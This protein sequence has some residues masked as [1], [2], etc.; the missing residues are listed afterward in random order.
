ML[1]KLGVNHLKN[2]GIDKSNELSVFEAKLQEALDAQPFGTAS[3]L[4]DKDNG[5][6]RNYAAWLDELAA[7][8]S[9]VSYQRE[10]A[11]NALSFLCRPDAH[12]WD[13]HSAR[14]AI[15]AIQ[16]IYGELKS[17]S[18]RDVA[19]PDLNANSAAGTAP[20]DS[21]NFDL[22]LKVLSDMLLL[23]LPKHAGDITSQQSKILELMREFNA[24]DFVAE[25]KKL[26]VAVRAE[27]DRLKMSTP[28]GR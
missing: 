22:P 17:S 24:D 12:P 6:A 10:D 26:D 28:P 20:T 8:L 23:D 3:A 21:S 9:A 11:L 7:D 19:S 16:S 1:L 2:K 15:W 13:F 27:I 18:N 5:V 14:Q 4:A 25:L